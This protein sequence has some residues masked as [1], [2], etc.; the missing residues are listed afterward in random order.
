[1]TVSRIDLAEEHG[2]N[3]VITQASV[4]NISISAR[5]ECCKI[6]DYLV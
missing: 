5:I 1:M 3:V 6:Y 2:V 4:L